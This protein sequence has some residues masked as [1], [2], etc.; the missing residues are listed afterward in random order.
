[1]R[2]DYNITPSCNGANL[3]SPRFERFNELVVRVI[4]VAVPN[5][6]IPE[7]FREFGGLFFD[8]FPRMQLGHQRNTPS[9]VSSNIILLQAGISSAFG[10]IAARSA[11][12]Q[13]PKRE[14]DCTIK[15]RSG[16]ARTI[17]LRGFPVFGSMIA[18]SIFLS[19]IVS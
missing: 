18:F 10:L 5:G 4:D 15:L 1:M 2:S 16:Y 11:L 12:P 6:L 7:A 13:K 14:L 8:L 17:A 9:I 3:G 19:T